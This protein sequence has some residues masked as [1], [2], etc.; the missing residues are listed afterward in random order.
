M[1]RTKSPKP[2]TSATKAATETLSPDKE[3]LS[4]ERAVA[5]R[6]LIETCLSHYKDKVAPRMKRLRV[7]YETGG[8][9]DPSESKLEHKIRVPVLLPTTQAKIAAIYPRN[10]DI[11]VKPRRKKFEIEQ[12]GNLP[13]IEIDGEDAAERVKTLVEY[14]VAHLDLSEEIL[15]ALTDADGPGFGA[16]ECG[17]DAYERLEENP[18]KDAEGAAQATGEDIS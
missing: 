1:A 16:V 9:K 13:P 6:K 15:M 12:G 11:R 3:V 10:P 17:W 5:Y 7:A 18:D 4:D 14:D 2:K 8:D